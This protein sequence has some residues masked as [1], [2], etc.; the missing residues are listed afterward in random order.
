MRAR[1][2]RRA[3]RY[4]HKVS[5][6]DQGRAAAE[7]EQ[8]DSRGKSVQSV[9]RAFGVLEVLAA[10]GRPMGV[11]E[12]AR[13]TALP[14]GTVHRLLL[15]LVARGYVRRDTGR[16]YAVGAAAL[17]LADA[18]HR[19]LVAASAP[20]LLQLVRL[21]G[22]TANLAVLEGTQMVYAAQSPSPHTLRIFAEVG[23]PVPVHSTAV[24]KAVLAAMRRPDALR[25]LDRIELIART[26]HTITTVP[27]L[28]SELDRIGAEGSAVDDEEHE[29]GVRCVAVPLPELPGVY[30]ALSISGPA[31]RLT[32]DAARSLAPA[33]AD[34][35]AAL[36]ATV[37]G[38]R[39]GQR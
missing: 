29:L 1:Q 18:A 19:A 11:A 37:L 23:R 26:P 27:A 10:H 8:D 16:K 20:Y 7:R 9:D 21:A 4:S 39:R 31:E 28:V 24:G 25:L 12:I 36:A 30:A 14:Q 3:V 15:A 32:L 33:M 22:E 6:T 38:D 13:Q 17:R 5:L 34:V 2:P 35:A